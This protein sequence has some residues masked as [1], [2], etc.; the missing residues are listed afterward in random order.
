M[1]NVSMLDSYRKNDRVVGVTSLTAA[2]WHGV[3]RLM[4]V[5]LCVW[6]EVKFFT[7]KPLRR[8]FGLS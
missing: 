1:L 4:L 2:A 8:I 3:A 6:S 5:Q 7:N